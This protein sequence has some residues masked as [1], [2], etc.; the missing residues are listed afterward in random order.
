M[1]RAATRDH[2][3][4][5]SARGLRALDDTRIGCLDD[6]IGMGEKRTAHAVFN[7]AIGIV[8]N[9]VQLGT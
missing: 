9:T 1:T 4:L 7:H 5:A 8:E 2:T 3:D 6:D